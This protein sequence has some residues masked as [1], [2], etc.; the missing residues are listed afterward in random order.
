MR[1]RLV[2]ASRCT[3]GIVPHMSAAVTG[4]AAL[5]QASGIAFEIVKLAGVT[6]LPYMAWA[7]GRDHSA[8]VLNDVPAPRSSMRVVGSAVLVNL[9]N[10]KLTSFFFA[11]LP[12]FVPARGRRTSW[13][14]CLG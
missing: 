14:G 6:Y 10:P 4:T 9:R 3:L 8:L 13:D 5:V 7:T 11:F 1:A 12:Q 2:A